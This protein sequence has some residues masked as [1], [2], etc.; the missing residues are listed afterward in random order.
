MYFSTRICLVT[1][2]LC[3]GTKPQDK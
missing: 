2:F 1:A 3:Q